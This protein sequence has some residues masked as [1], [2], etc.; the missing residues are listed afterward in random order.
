M[1]VPLA[2]FAPAVPVSPATSAAPVV[3][4]VL[5]SPAGIPNVEMERALQP[6]N[7][8]PWVQSVLRTRA[9]HA[10]MVVYLLWALLGI[11]LLEMTPALWAVLTASTALFAFCETGRTDAVLMTSLLHQFDLW[12]SLVNAVLFQLASGWARFGVDDPSIVVLRRVVAVA[13]IVMLLFLDAVPG[14]PRPIRIGSVALA[15]ASV[16]FINLTY[17][18]DVAHPPDFAGK[19]WC[20]LPTRCLSAYALSV[21]FGANVAALFTRH[22]VVAWLWPQRLVM[23]KCP[24]YARFPPRTQAEENIV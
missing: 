18:L 17:V 5:P 7:T 16:V 11:A 9:Y 10:A 20:P 1:F 2:T 14:V 24:L 12:Y 19:E 8:L 15:L 13:L 23:V 4:Q 21:S 3:M 22:L 6:V